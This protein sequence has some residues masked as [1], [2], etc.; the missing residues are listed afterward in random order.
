L[1][2]QAPRRFRLRPTNARAISSVAGNSK[3]I[4][5]YDVLTDMK[6]E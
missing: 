1:N 6:I 5:F 4:I 3:A 2:V